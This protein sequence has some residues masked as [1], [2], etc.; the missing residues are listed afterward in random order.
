MILE[1]TLMLYNVV[2]DVPIVKSIQDRY[3]GAPLRFHNL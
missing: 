2:N 3:Y 1:A